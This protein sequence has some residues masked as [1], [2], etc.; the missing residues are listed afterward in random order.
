[1]HYQALYLNELSD[2]RPQLYGWRVSDRIDARAER[3]APKSIEG[4]LGTNRENLRDM[5][6]IGHT[7]RVY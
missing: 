2:V 6:T 4:G 7:S 1:V 3:N 5:T